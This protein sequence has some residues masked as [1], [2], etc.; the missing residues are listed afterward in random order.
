M[1]VWDTVINAV[2]GIFGKVADKLWMDKSEQEKL[3][4]DKVAFIE[5]MKMSFAELAQKGHL[6]ELQ[7]EFEEYQAQR[8]YANSQFGTVEALASMGF[9]GRV[10]LFG[11]AAIRW[12]ITGGFSVMAW[13]ILDH[14]L[15]AIQAKLASGGTLTWVEFMI[16]AQILGV[17]LFYVCGV[18]IEKRMKVRNS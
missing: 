5:S 8:D 6:A 3:E 16:L 10:V 14:L 18:S 2:T 17:P 15:P 9:L 11:R 1:F 13:K 4:F 7:K 12:V